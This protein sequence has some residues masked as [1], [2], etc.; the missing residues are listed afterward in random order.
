[1]NTVSYSSVQ[2]YGRSGDGHQLWSIFMTIR[3][4]TRAVLMITVTMIQLV[5]ETEHRRRRS[6]LPRLSTRYRT[7]S[8]DIDA[9]P[10]IDHR[11]H[12]RPKP[13]RAHHEMTYQVGGPM[14]TYGTCHLGDDT[15]RWYRRRST[16]I[17]AV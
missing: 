17:R 14:C 1:M 2:S 5:S 13:R 7:Q 8:V 3:A 6:T 12:D 15:T 4:Q 10:F 9:H 16:M 11:S